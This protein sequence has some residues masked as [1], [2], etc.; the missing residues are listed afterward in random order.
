MNFVDC[1]C[2]SLRFVECLTSNF[3]VRVVFSTVFNFVF[4]MM[5]FS[6]T[7][8]A[9]SGGFQNTKTQEPGLDAAE[10]DKRIKIMITIETS[11]FSVYFVG[12]ILAKSV[13]TRKTY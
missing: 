13:N 3:A 5:C 4:K 8:W 10:K 9:S 11:V 1:L 2:F 7:N 12:V 6:E